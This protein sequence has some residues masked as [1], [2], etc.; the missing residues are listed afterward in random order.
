MKNIRFLISKYS[1]Y[2]F[3]FSFL[4]LLER[5]ILLR[6]FDAKTIILFRKVYLYEIILAV[7]NFMFLFKFVKI[8]DLK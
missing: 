6:F 8:S 4:F 1:I 5:F 7:V 3:L 2:V